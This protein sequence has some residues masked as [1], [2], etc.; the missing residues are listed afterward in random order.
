MVF[1]EKLKGAWRSKTIWFNTLVGIV[2]AGIPIV[3]ETLP[4]LA[5]FIP[6]QFYQYG[7]GVMIVANMILR[8]V[9]TQSLAAK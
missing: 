4:Q 1:I 7:M 5:P 6:A 9:T 3:Q 8:F 2:I